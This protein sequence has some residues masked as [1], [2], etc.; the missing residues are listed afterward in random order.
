MGV[1]HTYAHTLDAIVVLTT[2]VNSGDD[3]LG[4]V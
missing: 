1:I 3:S 2:V 4:M